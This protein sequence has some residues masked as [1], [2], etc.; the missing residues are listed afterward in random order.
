MSNLVIGICGG[1]GSGKTT[2]AKSIKE[3]LGDKALIISMDNFYK[4]QPNTTY[5][6]RC[7]TNY[8]HPN[9]FDTDVM[10]ECLKDLKEGRNT[11]IPIY[12]FTIHNRSDEPWMEIESK[13][14]I[15]IEGILLFAVPAAVALLDRK[16]YVDTDADIRLMRRL[17]RDM[18]KRARSFESVKK[19]Y[20][21]T[22]RPMHLEFVEPFKAIADIIVPEGKENPVAKEMLIESILHRSK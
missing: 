16:I 2:L 10:V 14:I 3:T 12:D 9:A 18:K 17:E 4:Y 15:I 7:K 1:S 6:E 5:E 13:P 21:E 11:R 8:D 19:Q 22:V 20:F